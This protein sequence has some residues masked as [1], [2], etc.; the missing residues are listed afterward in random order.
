[1]IENFLA[2]RWKIMDL[3]SPFYIIVFSSE[4]FAVGSFATRA[5]GNHRSVVRVPSPG[6]IELWLKLII[7]INGCG[8]SLERQLQLNM[9]DASKMQASRS[10]EKN[11]WSVNLQEIRKQKSKWIFHRN[12]K[13]EEKILKKLQIII[14]WT[15]MFWLPTFIAS[16][17]SRKTPKT[18]K[19]EIFKFVPIQ[20]NQNIKFYKLCHHSCHHS[21]IYFAFSF[22]FDVKINKFYLNF[23]L[24]RWCLPPPKISCYLTCSS[25][26]Q[27]FW[28]FVL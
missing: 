10:C 28:Y 27:V 7:R 3:R 13:G 17:N 25:I 5:H 20:D 24:I 6:G 15:K 8:G 1:M 14:Q 23:P 16:D 4:T 9:D 18:T 12:L 22:R 11:K 21:I 19:E 2:S 26:S